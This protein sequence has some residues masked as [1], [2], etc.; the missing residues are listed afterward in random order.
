MNRMRS[1]TQSHIPRGAVGD[2]RSSR[3]RD[4][5]ACRRGER[6]R[7]AAEA[8]AISACLAEAGIAPQ[9]RDARTGLV[10]ALGMPVLDAILTAR[11]D[12]RV[13]SD[14]RAEDAAGER[15]APW[16]VHRREVHDGIERRPP[17]RPGRIGEGRPTMANDGG[18]WPRWTDL[19]PGA[20]I[21]YREEEA[22]APSSAPDTERPS[23]T[24]VRS[25]KHARY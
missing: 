5:F 4:A 15:P 19:T 18:P 8:V 25:P 23:W 14:D 22:P 12:G 7:V 3:G 1:R 6:C 2:G 21:H 20:G 9:L 11:D 10:V 13:G 17:A 16:R 24:I